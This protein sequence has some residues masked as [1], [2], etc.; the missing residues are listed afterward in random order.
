MQHLKHTL[1]QI[2]GVEIY[3]LLSLMIFFLFFVTLGL[4]VWRMDRR[5]AEELSRQPLEEADLNQKGEQV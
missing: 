4:Y 2:T 5:H 3:P 1:E